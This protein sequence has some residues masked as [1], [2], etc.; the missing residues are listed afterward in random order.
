MLDIYFVQLLGLVLAAAGLIALAASAHIFGPPMT[1]AQRRRASDE[2]NRKKN[3]YQLPVPLEA[4]ASAS[5]FVGGL[6]ILLWT[7]FNLCDFLAYWLPPLP[8]VLRLFLACR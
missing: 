3:A 2:W 5:V 8:E 4:I 7:R 1:P 6:G